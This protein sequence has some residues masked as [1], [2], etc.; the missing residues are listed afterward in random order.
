ME[1]IVTKALTNSYHKRLS[2]LEWKEIIS[3]KQ[4]A[5]KMNISHSNAL[6]KANRQTI[7]AFL[8]KWV[9][10]IGI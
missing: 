2:Y 3:L 10:K 1:E 4:Y 9:W 8:E 5:Q 7:E 6:N